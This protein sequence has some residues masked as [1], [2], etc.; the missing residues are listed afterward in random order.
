MKSK[1]SKKVDEQESRPDAHAALSQLSDAVE[2]LQ[3]SRVALAGQAL[4]L[5]DELGGKGKKKLV[6]AIYEALPADLQLDDLWAVGGI[7]GWSAGDVLYKH[8]CAAWNKRRGLVDFEPPHR[9]YNRG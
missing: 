9:H 2:E 8:G 4:L 7:D 5:A 3:N 1:K 6:W